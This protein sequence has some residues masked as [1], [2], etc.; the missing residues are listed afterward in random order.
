[1]ISSVG[2]SAYQKHDHQ[3]IIVVTAAGGGGV[4]CPKGSA[5]ISD[6]A[7]RG[8]ASVKY[9]EMVLQ[10]KNHSPSQQQDEPIGG[11]G[12]YGTSMSANSITNVN[13]LSSGG[14]MAAAVPRL[15]PKKRKYD[16]T[17]TEL[18]A[19][20]LSRQQGSEGAYS[21]GHNFEQPPPPSSTASSSVVLNQVTVS[22]SSN[23]S[24]GSGEGGGHTVVITTMAGD[25]KAVGRD[26]QQQRQ[27]TR[28]LL[29]C[30]RTEVP[31]LDLRDWCD[32]R[33]L[34]KYKEG[35]SVYVQGVIKASETAT[36]LVVEFETP[37]GALR[38]T[39]DVINCNRLDI[40]ADA[41][42]SISD[43]RSRRERR[44]LDE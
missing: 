18:F 39:Y 28:D 22:C 16:P 2:T 10:Q 14:I 40:I 41:S 37:E 44:E 25:P 38:Q 33:V 19:T 32:T 1:M 23:S 34:A 43:V 13:G 3:S 4:R 6:S 31:E 35:E 17:E 9:V 30:G 8:E 27:V 36:E 15:H 42:P 20:D 11:G 12:Q 21:G 5:S 24:S 7:N 29:N 26:P